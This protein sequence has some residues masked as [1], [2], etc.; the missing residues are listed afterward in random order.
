VAFCIIALGANLPGVHGSPAEAVEAAIRLLD[1]AQTKLLARSR[2]Y[3]S[4]AWPDASDPEFVNAA[5]LV[6]TTLPPAALLERLHAIEMSF[7]RTR[8]AKNAPRPLD[9]DI[10]DYGGRLSAPCETPILPHPRMTERAFVLLPLREVAPGWRHPT[11]GLGIDQLIT[12]LPDPD[13]ARPLIP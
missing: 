6:E 2:L 7:G 13:T 3:R 1:S 8:H 9:L 4:D 5:A 10:I 12:A 11:S